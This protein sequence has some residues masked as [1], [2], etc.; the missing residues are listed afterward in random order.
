[1]DTDG[2]AKA[3]EWLER[4][5]LAQPT[6]FLCAESPWWRCHRRLIADTLVVRGWDVRHLIAPG[7]SEPHRLHPA[8]RRLG[9]A[10]RYDVTEGTQMQLGQ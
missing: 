1:M 2:F 4:E 3:L 7:R 6:A 9:T 10:L 8:A 5:A